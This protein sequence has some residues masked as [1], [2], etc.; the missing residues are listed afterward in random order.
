M[1]HSIRPGDVLAGRYRLID[2]LDE[3]GG[4]RFWRAHDSVL[5][6]H[7]ALHVVD[8]DDERSAALLEA[9]RRSAIVLDPRILRVL[10]AEQV[11][12][13]CYV[14]NE[15]GA[16]ISLDILVA[17]QGPVDGRRAAWLVA[18]VADAVATA[19]AAGVAHGRLVP[20]NVLIDRHGE[21]KLIGLCVDAALHGLAGDRVATDVTDLA[22]LLYC[23]LTGKWPGVSGSDV[24]PAPVQHGHALR[25]RRVRAGVP[26]Q[27]DALCDQVLRAHHINHR[28]VG[29]GSARG[30]ADMLTAYVGDATGMPEAWR[31]S[32]PGLLPATTF[33]ILPP[34]VDPGVRDVAEHTDELTV[35]HR[36]TDE[37][38]DPETSPGADLTVRLPAEPT[39]ALS[40]SPA[41]PD[42]PADQ[43]ADQPPADQSADQPLP[44]AEEL[45]TQAG[46]P[47][48]G[49]D[50]DDVSWLAKRSTPA[51]PPPPFRDH[52]ERPLFAPTPDDGEPTRR[53]RPGRA[54]QSGPR[55]DFWPFAQ[56]ARSTATRTAHPGSHGSHGGHGGYD[57]G[58]GTGR[59]TG[60][61]LRAIGAEEEFPGRSWLR[62]AAG[63][64]AGLLLLVAVVVAYNLGRG[65]TPLGNDPRDEAPSTTPSPEASASDPAASSAPVTGLVATDLDPQGDDG[66][67]NPD[68]APLAVDSDPTTAWSTLTYNQQFGPGGLKT[69]VGLVVDLGAERDVTA[70]DLTLLGS[71]TGV[72]VYVT[73]DAPTDVT[74]L[75][76]DA[77]GTA[78]EEQLVLELDEPVAGQYVVVW[79]TALPSDGGDGFRGEVAEIAV[80]AVEEQE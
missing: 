54:E 56:G 79:L 12:D 33:T 35:A 48:F 75:D 7:V 59:G 1:S 57:T 14:V 77:T 29:L 41:P 80:E 42:Q 6:R 21:V 46:M 74:D 64:A 16:G 39:V 71:P 40:A 61:G 44:V 9:A 63:I 38:T 58:T 51:P 65:K 25:P 19:H 45:P 50:E 62:L 5:E 20:E 4:G 78:D 52:P 30:I 28:S 11:D 36:R 69:G 60:T 55:D 70:L 26:G 3:S 10:D 66:A 22:G 24:P 72:S 27:L 2:L 67:E 49:D 76:P 37:E 68:E 47:I 32:V 34:L 17:T 31:T 8:A 18:Q 23:A 15:W 73:D 53:A 43:P 13:L